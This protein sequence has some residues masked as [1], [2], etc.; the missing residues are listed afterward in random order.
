M[1]TLYYAPGSCS[2]LINMLLEELEVPFEAVRVDVER[3]EHRTPGYLAINAKGKVPALATAEG[4]LTECLAIAEMLCDRH[5]GEALLGKPGTAAR[6][7]TMEAMATIATEIHP[8]FNR[9]FHAD[10]FS[11][12]AA[13][14]AAV[15][16]HGT[17]KLA[18]WFREQDAALTGQYW[19][20]GASP[21]AADHYFAVVARW[22]RW[23]DPPATR[24]KH[25]EPFLQRMQSRPAV[26]RAL[27]REGNTLF[28]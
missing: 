28:S 8:L 22:G 1:Y 10:D 15:K 17:G 21:S 11:A 6:A 7:R 26:A 14:Q 19:S 5:G 2:M 23:L 20:G 27:A 12:D 13:V 4:V 9:Y 18:A 3:R 24:M 16:A 25:I